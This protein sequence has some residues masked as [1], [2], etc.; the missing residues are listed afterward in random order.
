MRWAIFLAQKLV[1]RTELS[2]TTKLS[3]EREK[4]PIA[5]VLLP[6]VLSLQSKVCCYKLPTNYFLSFPFAFLIL[7]SL[8]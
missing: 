2:A 3:A 4:P 8:A 5:N 1:R 7:S 6:V